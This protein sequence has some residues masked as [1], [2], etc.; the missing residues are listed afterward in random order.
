MNPVA[1]NL[2]FVTVTWYA[3]FI[4]SGMIIGIYIA[5]KEALKHK[6]E[7][8]LL[9]DY[10]FYVI[11]SGLLGA[12]IW[13]VL[14]SLGYYSA[15]PA[16]IIAVWH[17]GL[18]I[19]GGL[20][21]GLLYTLYFCKKNAI[22][23]FELSDLAVPSLLIA[24]SIGRFGNFMNS[25]AHGGITTRDFLSGTL[26]LPDFIVNG[27]YID[28]SYYQPTFLYESV[29]NIIGFTLIM[30]VLRK[31][32]RYSYGKITAFYLMWYGFI[33]F[34]IEMMRTDALMLGPIKVA[35]FT[36]FVMF[37]AGVYI[38]TK[39]IRRSND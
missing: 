9:E 38:M 17:G 8:N 6:I 11:L 36:S 23:I 34:F 4:V 30:L 14:F 22:K 21:G 20:V 31:R 15:N 18:A 28:G 16:E 12:R 7:R 33:R 5:Q 35:E 29:W 2:G 37:I 25:E 1:L 39:L 13:Y 32:W 27:M 19:H 10:I 26:H 3:I 24:Q